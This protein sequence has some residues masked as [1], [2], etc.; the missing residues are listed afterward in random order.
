MIHM[1]NT[2]T[3]LRKVVARMKTETELVEMMASR[4]EQ[5]ASEFPSIISVKPSSSVEKIRSKG[6]VKR[7]K[8]NGKAIKLSSSNGKA[9]KR[10]SSGE[11]WLYG[12][13]Q[14]KGGTKTNR[15]IIISFLKKKKNSSR[16][17]AISAGTGIQSNC[18]SA[19]LSG[20]KDSFE[21]DGEG[22]WNLKG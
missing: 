3:D 20:Y 12:K 5:L 19:C 8:S 17:A 11:K 22:N 13:P 10:T 6:M 16:W 14:S 15:E 4:F 7:T 18:V 21:N 1:G 2:I 9:I